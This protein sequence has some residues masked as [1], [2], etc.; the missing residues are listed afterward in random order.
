MSLGLCA[1]DP[2]PSYPCPRPRPPAPV[3]L[4]RFLWRK[5]RRVG[6]ERIWRFSERIPCFLTPMPPDL[7]ADG[8][9]W[10]VHGCRVR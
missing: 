8:A 1:P 2:R 7:A 3:G 4:A 9:F 5:A 6:W 10:R